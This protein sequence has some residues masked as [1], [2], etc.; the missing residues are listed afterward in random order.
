LSRGAAI[1]FYATTALVPILFIV[2]SI[3]G[4][5][6]GPAAAR[7]ALRSDI[8][9]FVGPQVAGFVQ[10]TVRNAA[11][12]S[13]GLWA[14]AASIAMLVMVA[15]G[16]FGEIRSALNTVWQAEPR[17]LTMAHLLRTRVQSLAL[18]AALPVLLFTSIFAT[19]L[20]TAAGARVTDF[21]P[22]GPTILHIANFVATWAF[23]ALLF[24]AIYRV[25]PDA[26][27][28]WHDV[29]MGGI[30]TAL[31]FQLGQFAIGLYLGSSR[32]VSVYGAAGSLMAVLLW[33][34]YSAEI[35]LFGAE[36]TKSYAEHRRSRARAA[37]PATDPRPCRTNTQ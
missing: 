29:A 8:A 5:L 37:Q 25:L 28:T 11:Y 2:V 1:A 7:G 31:L 26:E 3:A 20:I 6:L 16:A 23:A 19:T 33:I 10:A 13:H 21:V 4:S 35:F 32:A 15:S 24:S 9:Q 12:T 30:T 36:L 22:I 18:V 34:F 14:N 17:P 27:L